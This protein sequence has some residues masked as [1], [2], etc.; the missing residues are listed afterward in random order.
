MIVEEDSGSVPPLRADEAKLILRRVEE[1]RLDEDDP[2]IARVIAEAAW[3][4]HAESVTPPRRRE[5]NPASPR[6]RRRAVVV[7]VAAV[8]VA[9]AA[10]F[11]PLIATVR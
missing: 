11:L 2:D 6:M 5:R 7:A 9:G 4:V 1:G 3:V 8:I 10:L